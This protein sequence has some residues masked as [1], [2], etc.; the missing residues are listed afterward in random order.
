M[1][2]INLFGEAVEIVP[3]SRGGRNKYRTMQERHGEFKGFT[4]RD[5]VHR[6]NGSHRYDK[7]FWKCRLWIV[8]SSDATDIRLKD[9]ACRKFEYK[10]E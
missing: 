7:N 10:R 2:Q 6:V 8:S 4:C 1:E 9:T 5:C 3:P